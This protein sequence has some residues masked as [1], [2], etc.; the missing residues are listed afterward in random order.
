MRIPLLFAF[1]PLCAA[2]LLTAEPSRADDASD[3]PRN[4]RYVVVPE[5]HADGPGE[6]FAIYRIGKT[7]EFTPCRFDAGRATTV[8]GEAGDPLWFSALHDH[9]L[10]LTRST[11]PD[12]DLVVYDLDNGRK[13]LDVPANR[14]ETTATAVTFWERVGTAD[15]KSCPEFA[16][17]Q[18]NGLGS[19][20]TA[21]KRLSMSD[22]TVTATGRTACE[23]TQ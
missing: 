14:Y 23:A 13:I 8:I 15:A 20:L 7:R 21:E 10:V 11:G 2:T 9:M 6:R 16:E 17:H 4:S 22:A 1:L 12:G 5:P 18:K 3:C 19:A